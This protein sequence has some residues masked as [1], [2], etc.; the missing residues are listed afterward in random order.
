MLQPKKATTAQIEKKKWLQ[1][2]FIAYQFKK[3]TGVQ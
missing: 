2:I 3:I 1:E